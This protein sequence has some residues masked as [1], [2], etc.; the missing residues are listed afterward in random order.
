MIKEWNNNNNNKTSQESHFLCWRKWNIEK[1]ENPPRKT[2]RCVAWGPERRNPVRKFHSRKDHRVNETPPWAVVSA[3]GP[4]PD[5]HR[6]RLSMQVG[7]GGGEKAESWRTRTKYSSCSAIIVSLKINSVYSRYR[8][9]VFKRSFSPESWER[10][11]KH[12]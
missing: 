12:M 1:P 8:G 9:V 11:R 3:R 5:R 2:R 6:L 10:I 4:P 7:G